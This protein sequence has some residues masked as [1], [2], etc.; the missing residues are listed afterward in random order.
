MNKQVILTLIE[1]GFAEGFPVI[2]RIREERTTCDAEIQ[3]QGRL[4]PIPDL[5]PK[6]LQW[7]LAYR[8]MVDPLSRSIEPIPIERTNISCPQLADEFIACF[9]R[10]LNSTSEEWQKIRD[11]LQRN[12]SK[13]E[14]IE[15]IVQTNDKQ[16]RQLPWHLWDFFQHYPNTEVTLSFPEFGR[17]IQELTGKKSD[18]VKILCIFGDSKGLDLERDRFCFAKLERI[19]YLVK[20]KLQDLHDRLWEEG[21]DIIFFAG[22]S[23]NGRIMLDDKEGISL[24]CLRYAI[25]KAIDRGLRLAIFNSCDGLSLAERLQELDLP[26]I[27]VMRELIP[28]RVAQK[29]IQYFIEAYAGDRSLFAAVREARQRLQSLEDKYPCATWLPVICRNPAEIPPKWQDLIVKRQNKIFPSPKQSLVLL[30]I[31]TVIT[32]SIVLL[33]YLGILQSLELAAFDRMVRWRPSEPQDSRLLV[34]EITEADLQLPEQKQRQGSLSDLALFRLL[35]KLESDRPVAIGLDI[36]QDT[37]RS[38]ERLALAERLGDNR[39]FFA[40]CKVSDLEANHPGIAPPAEIPPKRLGFSDVV[41]DPDGIVRRYLI[42]MKPNPASPCTAPY[43]FSAQLAFHYL[44]AKGISV[45]YN[46]EGNLQIGNAIF[47]RLQDRAGGYQTT[48][49]WGYQILLNYRSYRSPLEIAP[50]VTL[51]DVLQGKIK[52]DRIKGKIILIGVTAQSAHDELPTPY[53]TGFN[54]YQEMPGVILQAQM[55]SQ[56]LSA[57][58]DGRTLLSVWTWEMEILWI[59]S[60]SVLGTIIAWYCREKL[61]LLLISAVVVLLNLH[62]L[63]FVLLLEGF[64]VPLVPSSLASIVAGNVLLVYWKFNFDRDKK[65]NLL[66]PDLI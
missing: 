43:S 2:L 19:E 25:R 58:K 29:F 53:S 13:D 37:P 23:G 44:E 15:F 54:F 49:L 61:N 64:W 32:V 22:H 11:R 52:S 6:F 59:W 39:D 10:W 34:I 35:Q 8:Q 65:T 48:D 46:R 28:D 50:R 41:R 21:W 24:D 60:W 40:I 4:P 9:D 42:A 1:G 20:P 55:V 66:F 17:T 3:S 56:I 14:E 63:C 26:Q 47:K 16:L 30:A 12:L 36:Y 33:R 5:W 62:L 18:N 57:V 7:Q 31:S 45:K 27:I 38:N 51:A